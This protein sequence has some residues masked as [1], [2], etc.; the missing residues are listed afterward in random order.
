MW[1]T[2]AYKVYGNEAYISRLLEANEA[3]KEIAVFP[4]GVGILCPDVDPE[5]SRILPPWRR[6]S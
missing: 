1:D 4:S 2:V 3:L 6:G 5:T